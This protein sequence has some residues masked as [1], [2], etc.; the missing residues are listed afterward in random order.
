[1]PSTRIP[2]ILF[3][4][5]S[6]SRSRK[7]NIVR[8]TIG[9]H[10]WMRCSFTNTVQPPHFGQTLPLSSNPIA[11]HLSQSAVIWHFL[12]ETETV[13]LPLQDVLAELKAN[14]LRIKR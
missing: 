3:R 11:L 6:I 1:M 12:P 8:A 14:E 5:I 10:S 9:E 13:A 4:R 7:R 2:V